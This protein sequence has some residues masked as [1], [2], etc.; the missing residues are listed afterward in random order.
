[1][2][3]IASDIFILYY[4]KCI[5]VHKDPDVTF[6]IWSSASPTWPPRPRHQAV[7]GVLR[8][9][10]RVHG[11]NQCL[12]SNM[13]GLPPNMSAYNLK[14][15]ELIKLPKEYGSFRK[16][17]FFIPCCTKSFVPPSLYNTTWGV[18]N[19]LCNTVPNNHQIL[20]DLPLVRPTQTQMFG[21][22]SPNLG[23]MSGIGPNAHTRP[24]LL[25]SDHLDSRVLERGSRT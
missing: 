10:E 23:V 2:F 1:M 12:Q 17:V 8:T 25:S 20:T 13:F 15:P 22:S 21:I 4:L 5:P 16:S 6:H 11:P 3:R 9:T 19:F 24:A 18:R 7:F 14:F